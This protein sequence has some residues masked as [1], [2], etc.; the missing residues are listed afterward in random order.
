M[1]KVN[2]KMDLALDQKVSS[3]LALILI[4]VLS[5]IVAW[6]TLDKAY[7]IIANSKSSPMFNLENRVEK[8][9]ES[10]NENI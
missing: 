1:L 4:L 10:M 3:H 5:F 6:V 2:I 9:N 7:E 8:T